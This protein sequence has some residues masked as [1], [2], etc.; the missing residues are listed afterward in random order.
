M[1]SSVVAETV[2]QRENQSD[3]Q[4]ESAEADGNEAGEKTLDDII[5]TYSA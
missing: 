2:E 4:P 5:D 1:P 3:D